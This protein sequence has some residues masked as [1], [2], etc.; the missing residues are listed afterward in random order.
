LSW[1]GA[2]SEINFGLIDIDWDARPAPQIALNAIG[3]D[4]SVAFE[5]AVSLLDLR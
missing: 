1:A 5:E 4:G 3:A 2:F